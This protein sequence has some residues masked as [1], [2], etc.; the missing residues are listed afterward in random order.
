MKKSV[1][2][3]LSVI[4]ALC[5]L[6]S[7]I[8]F[9]AVAVSS[10]EYIQGER[11]DMINICPEAYLPYAE[12]N[13]VIDFYAG[14]GDADTE[15]LFYNQLTDR[16]KGMY[17]CMLNAGVVEKVTLKF[18][19]YYHGTGTTQNNAAYAPQSEISYDIKMAMMAVMED[20]PMVFWPNGFTYS[21]SY[22]PSYNSSTG[23]Y[24]AEIRAIN[25]T[26]S[27]DK[28]SYTDINDVKNHYD[29]LATEVASF[30][31]NGFNRYEKVKSIHDSLCDIITYP[32]NQGT[33]SSPNYGPMAH[34][35]TGALIYGS[36]VCEG[37]AEAFK[38]I[39]DREGIPCITV[40]G[41]G[42]GGGHKWNYVKMDDGLW[43]M[44]DA[45]WDDQETYTYYNYYLIGTA[46]DGGKHVPNGVM[47]SNVTAL[48]YPTL[49]I[50]TYSF[51]V[52]LNNTPDVAFNNI[53]NVL[54]VGKDLTSMSAVLNYIG[55]P[56][57]ITFTY[58]GSGTT[59]RVL[60]FTKDATGVSKN[61]VVAIRG[62]INATNSVNTADY[63]VL[64]KV[65][66]TT[67]KVDGG[68]AKFYAGD[69]NQDGAIDGFDAVAHQ[70]YTQGTLAFD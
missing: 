48:Q 41:Y 5:V 12:N 61:Y 14:S 52:P 15:Y 34:H 21:Y 11:V 55:L 28:N 67:Q 16:Q 45:T 4:T 49:A 27:F 54:Y 46:F 33:N 56:N 25:L 35:P 9:V 40:M 19:D 59:G 24:T 22:Y 62:D 23:N 32:E 47:F 18:N 65:C 30:K 53:N 6:L 68:T 10:T 36:S 58:S 26:V 13:R 31:V 2:K 17:D 43:Y 7:V 42:N 29:L 8:P 50:D 3:V 70:L 38:L 37:Y 39:C 20:N 44:L 69:M 64:T 60:T 1:Y 63:N 51:T 66:T 57:G